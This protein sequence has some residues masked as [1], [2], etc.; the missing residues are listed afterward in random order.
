MLLQARPSTHPGGCFQAARCRPGR[1]DPPAAESQGARAGPERSGLWRAG[2]AGQS[3]RLGMSR[4]LRSNLECRL[5]AAALTP[6]GP[7]LTSAAM[8]LLPSVRG[9]AQRWC[10]QVPQRS[11][12][13]PC[14]GPMAIFVRCVRDRSSND[15]S[16]RG[17]SESPTNDYP[18]VIVSHGNDNFKVLFAG[19]L[20]SGSLTPSWR[21]I[22][23]FPLLSGQAPAATRWPRSD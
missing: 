2:L 20:Q 10:G 3:A 6:G 12:W 16:D 21:L 22:I 17:Q 1:P 7:S 19:R 23:S 15:S 13:R 5:C 8:V 11:G 4:A 9:G 18:G 14:V